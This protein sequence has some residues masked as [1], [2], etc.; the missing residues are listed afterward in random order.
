MP[1]PCEARVGDGWTRRW[2]N[3]LVLPPP[4][5]CGEGWGT[6]AFYADRY[7]DWSLADARSAIAWSDGVPEGLHEFLNGFIELENL[8]SLDDEAKMHGDFR[9]ERDP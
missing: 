5:A 4:F 3:Y 1:H 2:S 6:H 8:M 9:A 7:N